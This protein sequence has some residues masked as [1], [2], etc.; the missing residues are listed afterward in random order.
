MLK[1]LSSFNA[2]QIYLIAFLLTFLFFSCT[3]DK[4]QAENKHTVCDSLFVSFQA[5]VV[6][7]MNANCSF[8][9]CHSAGS[10]LGDFTSY[11]GVKAKVDNGQFQERVLYLM[12]MPPTYSS[13][14]KSLSNED[15]QKLQCWI[16]DGAQNN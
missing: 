4:T 15:I 9:G 6:S 13:G 14:P 1:S 3:K 12:D 5:D 7:I 10:G 16:D 11:S 8:Y 2:T